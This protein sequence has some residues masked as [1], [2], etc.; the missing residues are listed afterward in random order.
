MVCL[1]VLLIVLMDCYDRLR[2]ET[3]ESKDELGRDTNI[4]LATS[5]IR[6][7]GQI[8]S[9]ASH[10]TNSQGSDGDPRTEGP[11]ELI[12]VGS[13]MVLDQ[14]F[15]GACFNTDSTCFSSGDIRNEEGWTDFIRKNAK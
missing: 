5:E 4:K 2:V 1:V 12:D 15:A 14:S 11:H 13:S 7:D 9:L 6:M 8:P 10:L 3:E